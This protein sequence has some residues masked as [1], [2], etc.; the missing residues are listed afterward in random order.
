MTLICGRSRRPTTAYRGS[1]QIDL[2]IANQD[3]AG[4]NYLTW[5]P[6]R[7]QSGF[8]TWKAPTRSP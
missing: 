7:A 3:A 6:S 5:T 2:T 1:M 8:W 4:R